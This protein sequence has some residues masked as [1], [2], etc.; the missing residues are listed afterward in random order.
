[1]NQEV[2]AII[3]EAIVGMVKAIVEARI[4]YPNYERKKKPDIAENPLE[5]ASPFADVIIKKLDAAGYEIVKK[6]K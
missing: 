1:M 4:Q 6:S 2:K 5:E 3:V